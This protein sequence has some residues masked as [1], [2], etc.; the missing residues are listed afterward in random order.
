MSFAAVRAWLRP[1]PAVDPIPE[2]AG[3]LPRPVPIERMGPGPYDHVA[4]ETQARIAVA[5]APLD[6][7]TPAHA[8]AEIRD[9]RQQLAEATAAANART[10]KQLT[11][12]MPRTE[13]GRISE[14]AAV[15]AD[16]DVLERI[17]ERLR[18]ELAAALAELAELR[19][20][21]SA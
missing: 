1:A 8:V 15:R 17:N 14:L 20:K 3:A 4:K 11:A 16:R 5:R 18:D 9:L 19:A 2:A 13:A 6:F 10:L 12:T 21:A 7:L